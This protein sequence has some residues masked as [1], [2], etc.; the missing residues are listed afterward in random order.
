MEVEFP[1]ALDPGAYGLSLA[2]RRA[3][4]SMVDL[5]PIQVGDTDE[6][7]PA[8]TQQDMDASLAACP[9]VEGTAQELVELARADLTERLGISPREIEVQRVEPTEFP[10]ASLGV[11]EPG[12]SYAQVITPGYVIELVAEGQV[13]RYHGDDGRV[14]L[15][16]EDAG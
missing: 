12:E 6:P 9:P 5:V 16:N 14:V 8:A 11:P 15:A 1:E 13:Y 4:G 3:G 7:G 10:D 2:V